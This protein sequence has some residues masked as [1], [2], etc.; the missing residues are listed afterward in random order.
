MGGKGG[1]PAAG[2]FTVNVKNGGERDRQAAKFNALYTQ[3]A[4]DPVLRS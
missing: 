3:L 1:S 2:S 4:A